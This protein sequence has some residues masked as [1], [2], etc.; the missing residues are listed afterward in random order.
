MTTGCITPRLVRYFYSLSDIGT[1]KNI[2]TKSKYG[3]KIED[4]SVILKIMKI[5]STRCTQKVCSKM[6][7]TNNGVERIVLQMGKD[8]YNVSIREDENG[9][10]TTYISMYAFRSKEPSGRH[11][12]YCR[13][14][15]ASSNVS[16]VNVC[17]LCELVRYCDESC[18]YMSWAIE[19]RHE[20][21]RSVKDEDRKDGMDIKV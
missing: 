8:V 20:C 19:H 17:S 3:R 11:C 13:E 21:E 9:E 6:W 2:E 15:F 16:H 5:L 18:Q 10:F 4:K 7:S 1:G 14:D 12:G